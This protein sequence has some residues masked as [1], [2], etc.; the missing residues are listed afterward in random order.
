MARAEPQAIIIY[1]YELWRIK[2]LRLRDFNGQF[3]SKYTLSIRIIIALFILTG[4]LALVSSFINFIASNN[5]TVQKPYVLLIEGYSR[6][7]FVV[8]PKK[9]LEVLSPVVK[10]AMEAE[11]TPKDDIEA[12]IYEIFGAED[13]KIARAIAIHENAY[14]ARGNKWDAQAFNARNSDGSLDVGIFQIN[15]V[16]FSKPN[17]HFIDMLDARKNIE[18]A[19]SIYDVQGWSPWVVFQTGAFRASL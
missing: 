15:S 16:H 13:Y 8:E 14:I 10:T 2:M 19:K 11:A 9:E 18:C 17:C 7:I 6:P 12:L 5:I 4:V 1:L 3:M